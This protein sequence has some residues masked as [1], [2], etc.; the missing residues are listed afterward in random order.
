MILSRR[1]GTAI[2]TTSIRILG[3]GSPQAEWLAGW[4]GRVLALGPFHETRVDTVEFR[5]RRKNESRV[6]GR[7]WWN[8]HRVQVTCGYAPAPNLCILV[9]E[10]AHLAAPGAHHR[11]PWRDAYRAAWRELT[12][13]ALPAR[14]GPVLSPDEIASAAAFL[15]RLTPDPAWVSAAF[16]ATDD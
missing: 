11:A 8:T 1:T 4:V 9:H 12:G 5:T 16:C 7:A 10:V 13:D 2:R 15:R 6:T 3:R 14:L